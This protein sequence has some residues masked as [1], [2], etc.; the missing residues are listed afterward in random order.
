MATVAFKVLATVALTLQSFGTVIFGKA[1]VQSVQI[2]PISSR[3]L[4][5]PRRLQAW[6]IFV[7]ME[8]DG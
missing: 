4:L 5:V 3:I 6:L 7:T 2:T 1:L 8:L